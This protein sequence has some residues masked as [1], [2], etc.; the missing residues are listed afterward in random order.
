MGTYRV[1]F[2]DATRIVGRHDFTADD[3]Q[4]AVTIA[5]VLCD[6]C[7]DIADSFEVW[8]G[9]RSIV[10]RTSVSPRAA[11]VI[12]GRSQE[13]IIRSMEA[14]QRSEWIVARSK[15]LLERIDELRTSDPPRSREYS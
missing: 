6:A 14:I 5:D 3:D 11:N 10:G 4:A 13:A 1:Y 2:R 7:S 15:K 12:M 8:S 9:N